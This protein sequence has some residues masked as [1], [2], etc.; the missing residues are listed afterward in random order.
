MLPSLREVSCAGKRVLLNAELN[1]PLKDGAIE[2]DRRLK[3]ALPTMRAILA[4]D[5]KQLVIISHLT[6]MRKELSFKPVV[7]PLQEA[8]GEP[9]AFV[10]DCTKPAP[11]DARVVLMENVRFH[12]GEKQNDPA[13]AK[14]LAQHCDLF[15]N[16]AFATMHRPY[17]SFVT[18]PG[19]VAEKAVGLLV[20]KELANL[21]FTS[22]ER[23]FVAVLG[24][25]KIS[26]KIE[27]LESLLQRVDRLLLGGAIVF[28]FFKAKGYEVGTSLCE[29]GELG[30]AKG[31]LE[32]YAEKLLLPADIVI[33]EDVE[34]HEIFT[35]DAD[36]IPSGMKGLD[37]GDQAIGEFERVLDGAKTVFWNGPLGVFEVPP[38]DAATKAI[39]EH[40]AKEK[41][42]VVIGGGDTAA[43]VDKYGLAHYYTHVSTGGGA[44]LQVVAGK[45]LPGVEALRTP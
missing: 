30:T 26:E 19:L 44:S 5:A 6:A 32:K 23:P 27:L 8:L 28:T 41:A 24:A 3:A 36:K 16:D 11:P 4:D 17:A 42:R 43:A 1:L 38:F 33:S 25:A 20:E 21:D 37:V 2:D 39:A 29:A 40:L 31:L 7:G 10:D 22:P 45:P 13:F 15:V 14:L 12:D 9:V 34:S 35:V 18:L